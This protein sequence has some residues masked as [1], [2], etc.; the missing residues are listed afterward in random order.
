MSDVKPRRGYSLGD[1]PDPEAFDDAHG[2]AADAAFRP[3]SA[4]RPIPQR[5]LRTRD[6]W[7]D[8]PWGEVPKRSQG[9]QESNVRSATKAP[10]AARDKPCP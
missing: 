2:P 6:E 4:G 9:S 8:V 7:A 10:D 3:P 1:E 5:A